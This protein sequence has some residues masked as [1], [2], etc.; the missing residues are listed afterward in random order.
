MEIPNWRINQLLKIYKFIKYSP[1]NIIHIQ[2]PAIGFGRNLGINLLPYLVRIIQPKKRI[3]ITLHEYHASPLIGR[4]RDLATILPANT[5]IVS[6]NLDRDSLPIFL[7]RKIKIIPIGSNIKVQAYNKP[8]YENFIKKLGLNPNIETIV[9]FGMTNRNKNVDQ[10]ILA[11]D[12]LSDFQLLILSELNKSNS[13]QRHIIEL[14]SSSESKDRIGMAGYIND[15]EVSELLQNCR[16]FI[17]PQSSYITP[18]TGTAISAVEHGVILITTGSDK[19]SLPF[20]NGLNCVF[21]DHPKS[22]EI[23]KAVKSIEDDKNK[24]QTILRGMK[25]L[26]GNFS[27]EKIREE[28][29]KLYE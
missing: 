22:G 24:Q 10:I 15:K 11:M 27:W 5:I 13:Y 28:H 25:E 19:Y 29:L 20:V 26:S 16:Y 8:F 18:K 14:I 1:A 2:Y 6:N 9:F 3:I 21:I 4:L 23:V 12:N 7:H 17:L